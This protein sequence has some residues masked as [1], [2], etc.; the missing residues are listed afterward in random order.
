MRCAIQCA[1]MQCAMANADNR[2]PRFLTALAA[3]LPL[4]L[5][6]APNSPALRSRYAGGYMYSYYVPPA[7]STPWRPAWSPDGKQIAFSM[8]GSLWKLRIGQTSAQELTAART[9]DS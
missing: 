1:N 4:A 7:A 6:G 2:F 5:P 9:N 3:L 8:A